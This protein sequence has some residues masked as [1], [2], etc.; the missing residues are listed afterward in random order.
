MQKLLSLI[1][2]GWRRIPANRKPRHHSEISRMAGEPASQ[3]S[4]ARYNNLTMTITR[5][6][7]IK[8]PIMMASFVLWRLD[9]TPRIK[10]RFPSRHQMCSLHFST[11]RLRA[12]P[13]IVSIYGSWKGIWTIVAVLYKSTGNICDSGPA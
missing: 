1:L 11:P 8:R 4:S 13:H 2:M 5:M 6:I 3:D 10:I 9:E 12:L 7:T